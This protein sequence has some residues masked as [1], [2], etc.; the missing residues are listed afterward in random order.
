MTVQIRCFYFPWLN[1]RFKLVWQCWTAEHLFCPWLC[2]WCGVECMTQS[3]VCQ[4]LLQ[5]NYSWRNHYSKVSKFTHKQ[6]SVCQLTVTRKSGFKTD[7]TAAF[8]Q[9][10]PTQL[11]ECANYLSSQWY[12]NTI[13]WTLLRLTRAV[14]FGQ[15]VVLNTPFEHTQVRSGQRKLQAYQNLHMTTFELQ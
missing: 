5:G 13:A 12:F 10:G 3:T 11:I 9:C 15:I 2:I 1:W 6:C 14:L 7:V 4:R 8:K